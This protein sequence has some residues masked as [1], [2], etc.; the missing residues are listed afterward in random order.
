MTGVYLQKFWTRT[1][2][3]L[4]TLEVGRAA[5]MSIRRWRKRRGNL[6]W[7]TCAECASNTQVGHSYTLV[8]PLH[9][10]LHDYYLVKIMQESGPNFLLLPF[11]S[12]TSPPE[13]R[14]LSSECSSMGSRGSI[15]D[16]IESPDFKKRLQ[17]IGKSSSQKNREFYKI[18]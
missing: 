14:A 5:V 15:S 11:Y 3:L 18:I 9:A 16:L 12:S 7:L 8:E 1:R 10:A 2:D 13:R 4:T 17:D 6:P